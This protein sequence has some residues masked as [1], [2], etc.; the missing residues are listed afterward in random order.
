[1][2]LTETRELAHARAAEPEQLGAYL[3][4]IPTAMFAAAGPTSIRLDPATTFPR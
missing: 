4:A 3:A 1:M 2:R